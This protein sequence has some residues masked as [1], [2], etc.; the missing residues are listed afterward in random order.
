M[1]LST[2]NKRQASAFRP[3]SSNRNSDAVSGR[4]FAGSEAR[5]PS[6]V[7]RRSLIAKDPTLCV[8]DTGTD[9]QPDNVSTNVVSIT[10]K[11]LLH[12]LFT[13]APLFERSLI[14]VLVWIA[15][16]AHSAFCR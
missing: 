3:R 9:V 14:L 7:S 10:A 12:T 5:L 1:A 16:A 8:V 2:I 11:K 6:G 13:V 4:E 15:K